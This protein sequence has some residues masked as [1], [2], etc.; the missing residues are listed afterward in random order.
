MLGSVPWISSTPC[1]QQYVAYRESSLICEDMKFAA[2]LIPSNVAEGWKRKRR[3]GA[4]QNHVS[5]AMGS[6]AELEHS[7]RSVSET[8]ISIG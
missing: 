4:Y 3:R 2:I 6:H 1:S 8:A 7:S 5:I